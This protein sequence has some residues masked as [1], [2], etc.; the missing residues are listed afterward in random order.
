VPAHNAFVSVLVEVG[1]LGLLLFIGIVAVSLKPALKSRPTVT[2][3]LLVTWVVGV[4]SLTWE[5]RKTTW[6]VFCLV[7]EMAALWRQQRQ[8][9]NEVARRPD[10]IRRPILTAQQPVQ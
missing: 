8:G 10:P 1:P 4:C 5:Y 7:A 2:A 3:I 9:H 6:L